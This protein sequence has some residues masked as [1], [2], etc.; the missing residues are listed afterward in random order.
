VTVVTIGMVGFL[1]PA[2]G[3]DAKP[4]IIGVLEDMS[5]PYS[6]F[7]GRGSVAAIKMAIDDAG[8]QVLGRPVQ[9]VSA[10]HLNKPDLAASIARRWFDEGVEMIADVGNS[11]AALAVQQVSRE[12]KRIVTIVGASVSDLT[13]PRCSP[14]SAH[15]LYDTWGQAHNT[16]NA[17][18]TTGGK[19]WFFL[20]ADYVFGKTLES[21][22]T[23]AI[24][25]ADGKVLGHAL[26]P[27][28]TTDFSSQLL[29]ARASDAQIVGLANAG[30]D[31]MNTVKQ[32]AE[33]GLV[34]D[35]QKLAALI[36][37][38]TDVHSLGL[39]TA[40][41]LVLSAGFYWDQND[42][43][44]AWSKRYFDQMHQM[45]SQVHAGDYSAAAHYLKAVVAAGTLDA[46]SVM[47]KM[48]DLPIE[49]FTTHGGKLRIDGRV[50]RDM[51]LFQVKTPAESKSEWDLYKQI[52]VIPAEE[53]TRPLAQG[54]CPLVQ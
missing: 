41:G 35:G 31:L 47:A 26:A 7:T 4:I 19:T 42:A 48:R 15:W 23:E 34:R 33:F 36:L 14:F 25:A 49:D 9:I 21:Q 52:S 20:T 17:V 30:T 28:G 39:Q 18:L 54:G 51:Y 43:T 11:A 13:G 53:A 37:Y 8:G 29:Q 10:D 1:R 44:R 5:G 32:A 50:A 6:D 45:P 16:A 2:M 27:L 46:E 12:K 40:Q 38:I 3:A 22:A 24:V